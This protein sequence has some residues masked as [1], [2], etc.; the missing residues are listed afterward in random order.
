LASYRKA[1]EL[2]PGDLDLRQ[3]LAELLE[4]NRNGIRYAPGAQLGEAIEILRYV[5]GHQSAVQPE[6]EDNLI[7]GLFYAGRFGE[8]LPELANLPTSPVR[9]GVAIAAIAA[10]QGPAAAIERANQNRRRRMP[11]T[12]QQRDYGTCSFTRR[13]SLFSPHPCPTPR[14]RKLFSARSRYFAISDHTKVSIYRQQI[15][16]TPFKDWS[17]V[18]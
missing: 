17:S 15:R 9:D 7:I 3:S 2:D 18:A 6:V 8:V 12:S 1:I 14:T 16:A 5:K 13:P 4:Y 11:S 10:V